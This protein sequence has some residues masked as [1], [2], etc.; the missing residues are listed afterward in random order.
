VASSSSPS[1]RA[2]PCWMAAPAAPRS[3]R[4]LAVEWKAMCLRVRLLPCAALRGAHEPELR[5]D[6]EHGKPQAAAL[7][8]GLRRA[9]WRRWRRLN[10]G[11]PRR[12]SGGHFCTLWRGFPS[13][14]SEARTLACTRAAHACRLP[15]ARPSREGHYR[16][17]W[18]DLWM[19][20]MPPV[21]R[22]A[23]S[24]TPLIPRLSSR[25]STSFG[26]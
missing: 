15:Q 11:A 19:R 18:R 6:G 21:A 7:Q 16:G 13:R 14:R 5:T 1:A 17:P 12:L 20:I 23:P 22:S 10:R 9:G 3:R 25:F 26:G 8:S 24:H 4:A 2:A